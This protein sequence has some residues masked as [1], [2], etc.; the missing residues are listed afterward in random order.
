MRCSR[1]GARFAPRC[2]QP[3]CDLYDDL[4]DAM[5]VTAMRARQVHGL[6]DYV[7]ARAEIDPKPRLARLAAARA[8]LDEAPAV[9]KQRE[10]HYRVPAERIASWAVNPTAYASAI[11]GPRARSTTSGATRGWPSMRRRALVT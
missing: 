11:S 10:P 5:H 1:S 8:A 3:R 7:D 4:V 6:Y 9:V 2:R